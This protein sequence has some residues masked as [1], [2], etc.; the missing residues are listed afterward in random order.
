[1][2]VFVIFFFVYSCVK[3]FTI[4]NIIK[5]NQNMSAGGSL[6]DQWVKDPVLLLQQLGLLSG[7]WPRNFHMLRVQPGEKK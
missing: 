3:Y 1:M 2:L 7:P 6:V 5:A 4:K